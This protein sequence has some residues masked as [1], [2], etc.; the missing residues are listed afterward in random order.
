MLSQNPGPLV[1]AHAS[2]AL[3][4]DPSFLS[5]NHSITAGTINFTGDMP[6]V[7]MVDGPSLGGFVCPATITTTELWKIGQVRPGDEVC[8]K[9]LTIQE[10]YEQ[11]FRV[12]RKVALICQVARG[13]LSADAAEADFDA[14]KVRF[15][16]PSSVKPCCWLHPGLLLASYP[17]T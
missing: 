3:H 12:D 1:P 7:L 14:F 10:A 17:S 8:F 13:A 11:R 9:K 4:T 2:L 15:L 16:G 6:I 5:S